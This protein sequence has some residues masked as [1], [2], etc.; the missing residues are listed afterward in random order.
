MDKKSLKKLLS[1][2]LA[3][4]LCSSVSIVSMQNAFATDGEPAGEPVPA[5]DNTFAMEEAA[6]IRISDPSGMRF[7]VNIGADFV[8]DVAAADEFGFLIFPHAY[9]A[10]DENAGKADWHVKYVDDNTAYG[11]YDYVEVSA[12]GEDIASAI[13]LDEKDGKY[14]ANGVLHTVVDETMEFS[15][16]AYYVQD[17]QYV[18]ADFDK[19]FSRSLSFVAKWAYLNEPTKRT[20][21]ES[22]FDW[23][24]TSHF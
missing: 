17:G 4:M 14:Y 12:T 16:I 23:L 13:Y 15:A 8:D 1:L 19:D 22:T 24:D 5:V 11:L 9:L 2:S 7:R 21:L 18:Y 10:E 20:A 3:T 6:S